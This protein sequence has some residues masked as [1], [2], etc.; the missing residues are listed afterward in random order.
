MSDANRRY[1]LRLTERFGFYDTV[2]SQMW[3]EWPEGAIVTDPAEIELLE[4]KH[5]PTERVHEGEFR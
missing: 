1:H 2:K 3:H 4:E 5:A